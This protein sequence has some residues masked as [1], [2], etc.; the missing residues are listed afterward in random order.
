LEL[1]RK[2]VPIIHITVDVAYSQYYPLDRIW[3]HSGSPS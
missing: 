2:K 3:K 1:G